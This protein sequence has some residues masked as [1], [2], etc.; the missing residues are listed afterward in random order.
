MPQCKL[1]HPAVGRR[2]F[3]WRS[4]MDRYASS[5]TRTLRGFCCVTAAFVLSFALPAF[6]QNA[7]S[8]IHGTVKDESGGAMP[9]VNVTI[10]SSELQVG[11]L[12]AVTEADGT[13]RL[14]D[15]PAGT[16][17]ITFDLAG[18]KTVVQ[19]DFKLAIGFVARVDATLAVGG[20]EETVTVS[21]ASPVVD[22]TTTTT[23]TN[24]TRQTLDSVPVGQ[25]LLN[26][27]AMTPG[28]TTQQIDVGDSLVGKR[29]A[30][31][32][33]GPAFNSTIRIDGIDIADGTNSGVYQ[34][35]ITLD[36]VQIRTSG[37]DAE[38]SVPGSAMVAVIKSG[39][40]Q[41]HGAY[42]IDGERP[43]LQSDN[44]T[45]KLRAQSLTNTN[46][47]VHLYDAS[48]DLGGR[49]IRDKLW[50][51]AAVS[52]QDRLAGVPG[53]VKSPKDPTPAYVQSRMIFSAVKVS[54]QASAKNR[55]I[56]AWQPTDKAQPQGLPPE[57][58]RFVPLSST[59]DYHNPSSMSKGE[60][61]S[62]LSSWSV[63]S[64][65]GGYSGYL[66][67]YAPWRSRFADP[68]VPTNPPTYDNATQIKGG[69]NP[70]TDI[71]YN[72][73]YHFDGGISLLPQNFLGGRHE[74]KIG[75]SLN[76]HQANS[77][78]RANP[79]GNYI[80]VFDT[81]NGVAH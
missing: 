55:L 79:A 7:G 17:K 9:G 23:S 47:I 34:S 52:R 50:F 62:T 60:L 37:N 6:A 76:W 21:G 57:P 1:R 5:F 12:S 26:L 39:S 78:P 68:V 43:E 19:S 3:D 58:S 4:A 41:F 14:G 24:L 66:G 56:A 18:F 67:D 49:I 13:Y 30:S 70:K 72:N 63:M 35:S 32:N 54:Y 48:A 28:L 27:Y 74:L 53:F 45:D 10:E 51:Y 22:L 64:L 61:Q 75:T 59:L 73:N 65:A 40:N 81:I 11:K 31:E 44:L 29:T 15:L 71:Q 16:Y 38:V 36:E 2:L 46:P 33:Y 77:G 8:T 25:G 20:L 80:L 69:S 42:N